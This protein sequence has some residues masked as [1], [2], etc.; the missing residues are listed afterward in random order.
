MPETPTEPEFGVAITTSPLVVFFEYPVCNAM[1][2][3]VAR[4]LKRGL[5]PVLSVVLPGPDFHVTTFSHV[6]KTYG[7]VNEASLSCCGS[8]R[9]D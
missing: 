5:F 1:Y 7:Q 4:S 2:P 3:P 8:S 6:T 9:I